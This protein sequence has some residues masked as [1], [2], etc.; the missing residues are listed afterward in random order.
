MTSGD[1]SFGC[2]GS[3]SQLGALGKV[4]LLCLFEFIFFG[5]FAVFLYFYFHFLYFTHEKSTDTFP[6]APPGS[7]EQYSGSMVQN[8]RCRTRRSYYIDLR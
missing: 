4:S 3:D 5:L 7:E 6:D 1:K 2:E 8:E